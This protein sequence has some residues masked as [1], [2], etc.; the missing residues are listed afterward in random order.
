[1]Y[2]AKCPECGKR[3]AAEAETCTGCGLSLKEYYEE[4]DIKGDELIRYNG[5]RQRVVVPDSIKRLG[6]HAFSHCKALSVILPEGVTT[7]GMR[8]F[9]ASLDLKSVYIP[10]SVTDI[11]IDAFFNCVKLEEITIPSGLTVINNG[12]FG[13]CSRLDITIPE[14]IKSIGECAFSQCGFRKLTIPNGVTVID[15]SAFSSCYRLK[16]VLIPASV[17]HI[18]AGAFSRW[19]RLKTIT[20][21]KDNPV[22]HSAGNCLI[23]TASGTLILGA[24]K[25]VIPDDGSVKII[26]EEAFFERKELK[27]ITIPAGV[28]EIAKNAFSY[29]NALSELTI[30]ASVAAIGER[31]FYGCSALKRINVEKGN[32]AYH[33]AGDCLIETDTKK[34]IRGSKN[35]VIPG[36]GSVTS[37]NECA[38][39][40]CADLGDVIIPEYV[41]DIGDYAFC[42][43]KGLK[44]VTFAGAV[45]RI[46]KDV[47]DY[48]EDMTSVTFANGVSELADGAFLHCSALTDIYYNGT[49]EQWKSV[50]KDGHWN[51]CSGEYTVHCA[52]GDIKKG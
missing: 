19:N 20:V 39:D 6:S 13:G 28:T 16:S 31:A 21:S 30:P 26:G 45:D 12:V 3:I 46:G 10:D 23:E 15:E 33:S 50:K 4:F 18:G 40:E 11:G 37:I 34:L 49:K 7:I 22:Y 35:S 44:S 43:C 25:S 36:D 2:F 51:F 48:C 29:C 8:A 41:T 1:M 14:N 38:F 52:D 47:F 5:D 42:F 27:H 32:A 17:T 24:E 9:I